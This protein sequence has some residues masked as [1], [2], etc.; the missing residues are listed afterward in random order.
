[1]ARS[2]RAWIA[3][4]TAE[5]DPDTPLIAGATQFSFRVIYQNTGREPALDVT[6]KE[7][8]GAIPIQPAF[9]DWKH[10]GIPDNN[11]CDGLAPVRGNTTI[12]PSI[13]DTT[14]VRPYNGI[15]TGDPEKTIKEIID[16]NLV[17]WING[18]FAYATIESTHYSAFCFMFTPDD[19][20]PLAKWSQ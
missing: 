13:Y 19:R 16:G 2:Q 20:K 3:P 10:L 12:Y 8:V 6:T 1:L 17:L 14:N 4:I 15:P 11:T 9:H 7:I 18:C 5:S